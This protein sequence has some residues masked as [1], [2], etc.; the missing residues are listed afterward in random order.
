MTMKAIAGLAVFALMFGLNASGT[1]SREIEGC[2]ERTFSSPPRVEYSCPNGLVFEA[3]AAANLRHEPPSVVDRLG[4]MGG[5]V[6]ITLPPREGFFQIRTPHAIASVR[7]TTLVVDVAETKTSVFVI[8]GL[9]EV[10]RMPENNGVL[11]AA[12]EGVDV[13]ANA[14]GP[15]T[16]R[17]W[18]L[19]RVDALLQRF[20][21]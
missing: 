6:L 15:L 1:S 18:P 4:L 7:G 3:E 21:R 5:A 12:G 20:G 16:K 9:V 11:L 2:R 19:P 14:A 10:V 17:S 13:D 8:E